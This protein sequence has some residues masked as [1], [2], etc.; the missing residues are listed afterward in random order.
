MSRTRGMLWAGA[1]SVALAGTAL[2]HHG[3]TGYN[4]E[5][6]KLSGTIE[7][8][9]YGNPHGSIQ[10]KT[11]DKTWEVVLAPPSRMTTR[12]LSE[13]M[14]KAGTSATVEGYQSKTDEKE[15]RAERITVAGKTVEL[16]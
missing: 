9:S 14:L 15:L 7:Q 12:G 2:A 5:I 6:Q 3:W 4:E 11:A 8:S 16:R 10:L 13:E 1:C